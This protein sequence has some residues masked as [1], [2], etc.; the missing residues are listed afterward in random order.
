MVRNMYL[1]LTSVLV[2]T[3]FVKLKPWM[4]WVL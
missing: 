1:T 2:S 3:L 4:G